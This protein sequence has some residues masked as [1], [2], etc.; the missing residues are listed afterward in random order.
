MPSSAQ[1]LPSFPRSI[2]AQVPDPWPCFGLCFGNNMLPPSFPI[3]SRSSAFHRHSEATILCCSPPS[4]P[5]AAGPPASTASL[6]PCSA[7]HRPT[8]EM[9]AGCASTAAA[10]GAPAEHAAPGM[11]AEC[12]PPAPAMALALGVKG[13]VGPP[14]PKPILSPTSAQD[15]TGNR[16]GGKAAFP[17]FGLSPH[18]GLSAGCW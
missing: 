7:T 10:R 6:L 1:T 14:C 18:G 16:E 2:P 13:L 17:G 9:F 12:A 3:P 11:P 15:G 5:A 8:D 4:S